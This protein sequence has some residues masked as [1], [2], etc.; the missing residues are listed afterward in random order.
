M[1]NNSK[2]LAKSMAPSAEQLAQ[3]KDNAID[4]MANVLRG[5]SKSI[6]RI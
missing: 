2:E 4:I 1:L 6:F 3:V 5:Y